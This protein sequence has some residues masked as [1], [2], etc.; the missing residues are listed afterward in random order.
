MD[1]LHG[2]EWMHCWRWDVVIE[3]LTGG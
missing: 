2:S 3:E 1:G